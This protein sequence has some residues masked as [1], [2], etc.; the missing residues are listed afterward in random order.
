MARGNPAYILR[1]R[2]RRRE[3]HPLELTNEQV[4]A[5]GAEARRGAIVAFIAIVVVVLLSAF[6]LAYL[7]GGTS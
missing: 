2:S 7:A 1:D 5:L 6:V 3:L 4:D